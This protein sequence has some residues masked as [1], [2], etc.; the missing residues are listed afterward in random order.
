MHSCPAGVSKLQCAFNG[1]ASP[2]NWHRHIWELDPEDAE[3]NGYKNERLLSWMRFAPFGVFRKLYGRVD[4]QQV[5]T[6]RNAYAAQYYFGKT[7]SNGTYLLNISYSRCC[8]KKKHFLLNTYSSLFCR[9]SSGRFR[10]SKGDHHLEHHLDGRKI[11][12]SRLPLHH[13]LHRLSV[14]SDHLLLY[15][16]QVWQTVSLLFWLELKY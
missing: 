15:W 4:H 1:T 8:L 10:R 9:L 12:L 7:L 13:H 2:P 6:V 11:A 14:H 5:K 16:S 3:N